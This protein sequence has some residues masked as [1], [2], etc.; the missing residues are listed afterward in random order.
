M[1]WIAASVAASL[2]AA[3]ALSG[4][5]ASAQARVSTGGSFVKASLL[6]GEAH[7]DGTRDAGLMLEVKPGWKTYWRNPGEAG[8]PPRLDWSASRNLADLRIEWPQPTLF[9]SFGYLTLGYG[10][11][12]ILPITLTAQDPGAPIDL[13]LNGMLGVCKDIC[14]FEEIDLETQIV[15][16]ADGPDAPRIGIARLSVPMSGEEAGISLGGCRI[17]GAGYD[18]SFS[19]TLTLP[20]GAA[21]PFVVL[22]G[23]EGAWF[24]HTAV[25]SGPDGTTVTSK[26]KLEEAGAWI[27]RAGIS[28]TVLYGG[29]A[30]E[31]HGCTPTG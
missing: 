23:P 29:M 18:R 13:A 22:E 17:A 21:A 14:V 30:A 31:V 27:D 3:L 6:V 15:P 8:V 12:V 7:A 19:A 16:G 25:A 24:R 5:E 10:G 4:G 20:D 26:L 2:V 11:R 9:E 1:N 28:A